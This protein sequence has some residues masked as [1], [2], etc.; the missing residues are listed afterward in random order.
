MIDSSDIEQKIIDTVRLV[1]DWFPVPEAVEYGKYDILDKGIEPYNYAVLIPTTPNGEFSGQMRAYDIEYQFTLTLFV[2]YRADQPS[3]LKM[4]RM[5]EAVLYELLRRPT[6][7]LPDI[8]PQK[9]VTE[10]GNIQNVMDKN[11]N[12]PYFLRCDFQLAYK[13]RETIEG[14]EYV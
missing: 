8:V 11:G 6:L 4:A 14:G 2:Q 9:P 3:I 5:R 10:I 1:T 13:R 12:G 7:G